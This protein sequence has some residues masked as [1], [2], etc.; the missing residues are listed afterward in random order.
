M[1]PLSRTIMRLDGMW[2]LLIVSAIA[3]LVTRLPAG[4][5]DPAV[6]NDL[7]DLRVGMTVS[8]I[9][10][11]EYTDFHCSAAPDTR[12]EAFSDYGRCP[13]DEQGR[14]GIRF[15][16]D[17]RTNVLGPLDDKYRGTM[18]GGHPV[19]LT[20][21]VSDE[22]RV[23][24]LDIET[25]SKTRLFLRKKAHLLGRQAMSYYGDDGWSCAHK[26]PGTDEAPIGSV[27]LHD[28]CSKRFDGR[29][30][31]VRRTFYRPVHAELKDF[32]SA[33][34]IEIHTIE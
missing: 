11:G 9:P 10:A 6:R 26:S 32:V 23:V 2:L 21:L 27:F 22:S 24:G 13:T 5:A 20:L 17:E 19:T 29:E 33:T 7:R 16:F 12:I 18:V 30:I 34:K 3:V 28:N 25:D 31:I 1:F 15:A 4:A 8:E 14:H